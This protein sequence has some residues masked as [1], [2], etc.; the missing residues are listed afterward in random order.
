VPIYQ[1]ENT[2]TGEQFELFCK[3]A[4]REK[5]LEKNPHFRQLVTSAA[6]I[7]GH[8]DRTKT[9]SGMK[10]VF[11]KIADAHPNSALADTY[12]KK[13]ANSI[14]RREWGKKLSE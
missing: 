10:E 6:S 11:S 12:G 3:L 5:I 13:D 8:G 4:D 14:R 7:G 1:F 2:E 9:D